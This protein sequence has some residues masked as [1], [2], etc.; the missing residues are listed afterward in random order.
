MNETQGNPNTCTHNVNTAVNVAQVGDNPSENASLAYVLWFYRKQQ[1][2]S[3]RELATAIG[4][5]H[6]YLSKIENDET[7]YTPSYEFLVNLADAL[8][9]D[10]AVVLRSAGV[11]P[12]ATLEKVSALY[13]AKGDTFLKH[14]DALHTAIVEVA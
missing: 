9:L 6:T 8:G 10:K 3:Q 12:L 7:D 14:I 11:V 1:G 13:R 4:V 5:S 2:K